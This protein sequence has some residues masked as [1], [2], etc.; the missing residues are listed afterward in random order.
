VVANEDDV[1]ALVVALQEHVQQQIEPFGHVLDLLI[2]GAGDVHQAEHDRLRGGHRP[3]EVQ[4]VTQVVGVQERNPSDTPFQRL[5]LHGQAP[6]ADL[7]ASR[8]GLLEF[9]P[10]SFQQPSGLAGERNSPGF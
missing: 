2:H 5:D 9:L 7:V 6:G 10:G 3:L 4:V 8:F 1:G